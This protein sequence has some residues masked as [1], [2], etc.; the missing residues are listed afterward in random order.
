MWGGGIFS[1]A[2]RSSG[3][4]AKS[5]SWRRVVVGS[6]PAAGSVCTRPNGN[7]VTKGRVGGDDP[8]HLVVRYPEPFKIPGRWDL[9][10]RITKPYSKTTEPLFIHRPLHRSFQTDAHLFP[11]TVKSFPTPLHNSTSP[12]S[13]EHRNAT[14]SR[15][16]SSYSQD[17]SRFSMTVHLHLSSLFANIH[18]A[19]TL[20][21]QT[22]FTI[23]RRH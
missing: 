21:A 16:L 11:P 9:P 10:G 3:A 1:R 13:R 7:P 15:V 14:H 18:A 8:S 23:S 22:H 4:V 5:R 6:K 20:S 12:S 2:G 17:R 19:A